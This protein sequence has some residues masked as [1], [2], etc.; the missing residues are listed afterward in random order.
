M[1]GY[2]IQVSD[3][4]GFPEFVVPVDDGGFLFQPSNPSYAVTQQEAAVATAIEET[5]EFR[6]AF[7]ATLQPGFHLAALALARA[8]INAQPTPVHCSACLCE[9][10]QSL[11]HHCNISGQEIHDRL[12][13]Y[14][15]SRGMT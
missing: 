1:F 9:L 11:E 6:T 5:A 2:K 4:A 12:L 10:P 7:V 14:L 13:R 15:T 8:A 3:S